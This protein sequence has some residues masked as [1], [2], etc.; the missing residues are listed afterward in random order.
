MKQNLV[1]KYDLLQKLRL[2][3]GISLVIYAFT[4]LL[5]HSLGIVSLDFM[6]QGRIVFLGFWRHPLISW[7]VPA[8]VLVHL[9]MVLYK[10]YWKNTFRGLTRVEWI[11]IGIG[12]FI[13]LFLVPHIYD[14]LLAHLF[15]GIDDTYTL[16]LGAFFPKYLADFILVTLA[17]WIHGVIG[18]SMYLKQKSWFRQWRG[19]FR[20]VTT[21]VPLLGLAGVI[22]AGKETLR[23]RQDPVWYEQVQLQS[24]TAGLDW[25]DDSELFIIQFGTVYLVFLL[26][27][28]LARHLRLK[29]GERQK[30]IIVQ[31][32]DGARVAAG[33]GASLLEASLSARIPHAHVCGGR[34][35][36][37]TCRVQVTEGVENLSPPGEEELHLL[38]KV[39][40]GKNVR[41]AC[42][43]I[44]HGHCTV[45]PL[46]P[47]SLTSAAAAFRSH[48]ERQGMDKEIAILFSD[49][50]GF[51]SL[52]E[53]KLPFD[54]VHLLNQYYQYMGQA[55]E[56]NGGKVDKFI[57]DGIMALFGL[58]TG[59]KT[60]CA[61][62]ITAARAMAGQLELLNE[63]LKNELDRPLQI[64]M[65]IHC[66]P[67][68]V[69]EMGYREVTSFTAIGDVANTAS[70]LEN[71]CKTLGCELVV[72]AEVATNAGV[73]FSAFP[74]HQLQVRGRSQPLLV[75]SLHEV[76]KWTPDAA[77]EVRH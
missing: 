56:A 50:R 22:S 4:H 36:C 1:A 21:S 20:I 76:M 11:Q 72:S 31:Y 58:K 54:V 77:G 25:Q 42:K 34:G 10:L 30:N 74:S 38:K 68:I 65:G 45:Y 49:L 35:R 14:T 75:Y 29:I 40:A 23:L 27:F 55:I 32:L 61:Q 15:Y 37:S 44:L 64:G 69:G 71:E 12:L 48:P 7:A 59:I 9:L 62:A 47:A 28:F 3:S 53:H 18:L 52:T 70:R 51:T 24:N 26:L 60:G 5:N 63:S 67:V 8:A 16:Y 43:S 57:G 46:L 19:T 6:E 66:G 13:P 73:D 33:E 17:V 39:K 2:Y 41:L